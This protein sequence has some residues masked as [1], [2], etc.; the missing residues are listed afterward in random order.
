[1]FVTQFTDEEETT[2]EEKS[3]PEYVFEGFNIE[4]SEKIALTPA[5]SDAR[6]K[7]KDR[8]TKG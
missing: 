5:G 6:F 2:P 1:M 4:F 8:E 7:G 3:E